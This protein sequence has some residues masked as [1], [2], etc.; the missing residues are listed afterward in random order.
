MLDKSPRDDKE[1]ADRLTAEIALRNSRRYLSTL[2]PDDGPLARHLYP[3][4]MEFFRAGKD[5][6]ERAFCGGN[7]VGKTIG[8]GGYELTL[9]LTGFY[10]HWWEGRVFSIPISAWAAGKTNESTRDIIQRKLLGRIT[11]AGTSNKGVDG[12]GLIPGENL[13]RPTW[14][15]GTADFVDA[16]P[17]LHTPTGR[18]SHLGFKSYQQGSG[19]FEGTEQQVIWCDEE[20]PMPIYGECLIRTAGTIDVPDSSGIIMLTYT[21]K[22]GLSDVTLS[23]MRPEDRPGTDDEA[24]T[25]LG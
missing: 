15:Q 22:L 16:I 23:F 11:G 12:T 4:H 9:H 10:P 13:G 14:K 5:Y 8:A 1:E 6:R 21:P 17:V 19:S 24:R 18:W 20:P 7:R 3:K 25:D 2:Y